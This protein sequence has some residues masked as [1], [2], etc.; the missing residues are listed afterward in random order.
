MPLNPQDQASPQF[1][2]GEHCPHC[3]G[4]RDEA[5]RARYAERHKQETLAAERGTAHLGSLLT[6]NP[7]KA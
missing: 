5:S 7:P 4:N 1:L 2:A 6:K 3:Y